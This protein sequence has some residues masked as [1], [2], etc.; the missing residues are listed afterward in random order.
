MDLTDEIQRTNK[1]VS[2]P[3]WFS[4]IS[5]VKLKYNRYLYG[6]TSEKGVANLLTDIVKKKKTVK[7]QPAI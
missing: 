1:S 4:N 7:N 5:L 2:Y 6:W 3:P